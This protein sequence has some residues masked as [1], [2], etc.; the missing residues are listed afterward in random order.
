MTSRHAKTPNRAAR[1]SDQPRPPPARRI[2]R[3]VQVIHDI[4]RNTRLLDPYEVRAAWLQL[5]Q[6]CLVEVSVRFVADRLEI[7]VDLSPSAAARASSAGHFSRGVELSEFAG[8]LEIAAR[9][10]LEASR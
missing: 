2:G 8:S 5:P 1:I 10:L 9:E 6:D 7:A 3:T 4:M